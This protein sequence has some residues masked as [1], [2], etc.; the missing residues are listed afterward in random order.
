MSVAPSAG[1]AAQY[2][3]RILRPL[4]D[5]IV[6]EHGADR[7]A[8]ITDTCG[9]TSSDLDG[10]SHWGSSEQFEGFLE[11]ARKLVPDDE[12]FKRACVY[13]LAE[14]YGPIRYVLW[15][16]SPYAVYRQAMRTY[17]MMATNDPPRIM[18]AARTSLHARFEGSMPISRLN[19]LARQAQ[20]QA[21][22]TMWGLPTAHLREEGCLALGDEAC[23]YHLRWFDAKRWLPIAAGFAAGATAA[24]LLY[25]VHSM[26]HVA[27][28]ALPL[29]GLCI[30]FIYE[31]QR[32]GRA[33]L[34]VGNEIN[35][36]LEKLAD[37]ETDARRE[38]LALHERQSDWSRMLEEETSER[39]RALQE[40]V[41]RIEQ[42]QQA[43]ESTLRGFSHDLRNPLAI[44]R[45]VTDYLTEH[46]AQ[47]GDEG[48]EIVEDL[49]R[50]VEQMR[51]L[52]E[53]LMAVATAKSNF[54]QLTP[55]TM[56]VEAITERL[57]RRLRALVYGR[58][59]R[60]SV[61]RT[62]EAPERV[63]TDALLFDRVLD[64]LLT[65]AAKYTER[66]SI[67]VELDGT[68]D[69]LV[70]KVSDTGRGIDPDTLE[71]TFKP[72]GSDRLSRAK[73]SYGIGLSVVVHLLAQVGGQLEVMSK[74]A[75]GTTFGVRF[76][77]KMRSTP[78][79]RRE[80]QEPFGDAMKRVVTIRR[81]KSA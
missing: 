6:A 70:I 10:K 44:L 64:N 71:T 29:L 36:A 66:G 43:R 54:M 78:P 58:D 27:S 67:V 47:L 48:T 21:L 34:A 69:Y 63:I 42:L 25:G 55:K 30:G 18:S 41:E 9:V 39:A 13:K 77:L 40:M 37:E 2:N 53:D 38:I 61:F 45:A 11:A 59:I 35:E 19:C 3:L 4:A 23:V 32:T 12:A 15:A 16:T 75:H 57:R 22:P 7:L 68:P 49:D 62:R 20:T 80:R 8:S 24:F 31:Q 17:H 14:S 81:V 60:V 73:D 5:F 76:P 33:N 28:V 46:P 1:K 79:P 50:A 72:G 51:R 65:N 26:N 74:P 56:E 52:L